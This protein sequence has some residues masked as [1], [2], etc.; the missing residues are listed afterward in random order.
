MPA[1]AF[2]ALSF[3]DGT[4]IHYS[5]T[6]NFT[7]VGRWRGDSSELWRIHKDF[8]AEHRGD[9]IREQFMALFQ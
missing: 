2:L 3:E 8:Y 7:V 5:F 4:F 9:E 6:N 1:S